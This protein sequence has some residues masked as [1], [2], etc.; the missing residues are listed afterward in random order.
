M[1][2]HIIID[3]VDLNDSTMHREAF[4]MT[5][6][7]QTICTQNPACPDYNMRKQRQKRMTTLL[8][9]QSQHSA[10]FESIENSY[11]SYLANLREIACPLCSNKL[12][13]PPR[14]VTTMP[15]ILRFM[16]PQI[17]DSIPIFF[18]DNEFIMKGVSNDSACVYVLAGVIYKSR[19]HFTSRYVDARHN[20][21]HYDG[22]I[23][24]G[25][26]TYLG[27]STNYNFPTRD[28]RHF[29]ACIALYKFV[30]VT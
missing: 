24:N 12:D 25:R 6:N 2:N 10:A 19:D 7:Q 18:M 22:M 9:P 30:N 13:T 27:P 3:T 29:N 1:F 16:L 14:T 11:N 4:H 5:V 17:D 15:L 21:Y 20:L 28:D 8:L 26:C 23:N